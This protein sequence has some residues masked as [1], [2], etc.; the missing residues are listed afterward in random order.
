[1]KKPSLFSYNIRKTSVV[2]VFGL[3]VLACGKEDPDMFECSG[4]TPTYD[5]EVKPILDA[6][7]AKVGCHDAITVQNGVNLSTYATASVISQEDR[8]LG[9]IQHKSGFPAMPFDGPKLP[10]AT[11]EILTCWVQGGSPQ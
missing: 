4:A 3:L 1:M 9:V 7:C 8:F 5:I 11:I 6:S 2:V 10:D